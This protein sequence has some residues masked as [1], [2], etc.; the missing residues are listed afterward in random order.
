MKRPPYVSVSSCVPKF[1]L[2]GQSVTARLRNVFGGAETFEANMSVGSM[3]R[4]AFDAS[5]TAPLT[6]NLNT[7]GEMHLFG[8]E[9][10]QSS[11]ASCIESIRGAKALV[12]VS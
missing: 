9:R 2:V 8:L 12:R 11:F 6:S 5:F 4:K 1:T 10:D 3:T 7:Y